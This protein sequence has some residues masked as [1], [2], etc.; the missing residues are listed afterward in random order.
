VA[1]LHPALPQ[2]SRHRRGRDG[3]L[4]SVPAGHPPRHAGGASGATLDRLEVVIPDEFRCLGKGLVHVAQALRCCSSTLKGLVLMTSDSER[5]HIHRASNDFASQVERLRVQ[6][7]DMLAG[8]SCC[9]ELELLALPC[10]TVKTLFPPGCAFRRLT[11]LE[12]S[13]DEGRGE[14]SP[15]TAGCGAGLWEVMASGGLPPWPSSAP[16]SSVARRRRR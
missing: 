5:I 7:A 3:R 6:W 12:I 13:E 14:D 1:R 15:A 2:G 16:S 9:R 4:E 8:V 10:I 11:D